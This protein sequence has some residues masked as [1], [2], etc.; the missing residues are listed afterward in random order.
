M[1][2]SGTRRGRLS[3]CGTCSSHY[4]DRSGGSFPVIKPL[5]ACEATSPTP[6]GEQR[7]IKLT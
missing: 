1:F 3:K 2:E 6:A 4:F 7:A 5:S